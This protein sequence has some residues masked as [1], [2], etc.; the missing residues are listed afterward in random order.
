MRFADGTAI[1]ILSKSFGTPLSKTGFK[2]GDTAIIERFEDVH[3]LYLIK[4][5]HGVYW[6]F[7]ESDLELADAENKGAKSR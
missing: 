1:R 6:G 2:A 4:D 3:Q 7:N 5:E